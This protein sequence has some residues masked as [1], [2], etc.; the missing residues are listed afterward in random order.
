MN[1]APTVRTIAASRPWRWL[2]LGWRDFTHSSAGIVHGIAV[3]LAGWVIVTIGLRHPSLLP[4]ALSG[5]VL[6]APLVATGLY[7]FSRRLELGEHPGLIEALGA[8][9]REARP[10]VQLG[11]LLL[12][13]GSLWVGVSMALV[14]IYLSAP[15]TDLMHYLR[16]VLAPERQTLFLAWVLLGGS[17]AAVVFGLTA[18]SM[19]ML[20]DRDVDLRC[21][22][23][24]SVK[25]VGDNPV[26]MA[27][28]ATII[29]LGTLLGM[30]TAMLGLVVIVPVLGHATWHAYRDLVDTS[31]LPARL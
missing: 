22:L 28:W 23:M 4:G 15:W 30:A 29:M 13:M 27:L 2:T 16:E 25:A 7:E 14:G 20:L 21:A 3:M 31:A 5:F 18:I 10:L 1:A 8:W 17:G 12:L 24:T 19:P 26:P 6:V 11:L 9:R